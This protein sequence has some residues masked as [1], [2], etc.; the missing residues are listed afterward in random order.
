MQ[1]RVHVS[2]TCTRCKQVILEYYNY[3]KKI[4]AINDAW[5]I[6]PNATVVTMSRLLLTTAWAKIAAS[7]A[8]TSST[9]STVGVL[10]L[11]PV[12]IANKVGTVA[13]CNNITATHP[14]VSA[15]I[16]ATCVDTHS[17]AVRIA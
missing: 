17:D 1:Q 3:L 6:N 14:S 13:E 2:E 15:P 11:S 4:S 12:R 7:P 16:S 10:S 9:R 5:T 8:Q